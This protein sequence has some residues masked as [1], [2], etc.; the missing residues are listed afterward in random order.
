MDF[1]DDESKKGFVTIWK[2]GLNLRKYCNYFI[3]P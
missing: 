2:I 1:I 3:V